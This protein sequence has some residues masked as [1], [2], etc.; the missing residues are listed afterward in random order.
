MTDL[1]IVPLML[2]SPSHSIPTSAPS[3]VVPQRESLINHDV[4]INTAFTAF[5][6]AHDTMVNLLHQDTSD[7]N[8][9]LDELSSAITSQIMSITSTTSLSSSVQTVREGLG[10]LPGKLQARHAH[11]RKQARALRRKIGG[12]DAREKLVRARS[13]ARDMR[14]RWG[15]KGQELWSSHISTRVHH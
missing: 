7:L 9:A 11:A 13:T 10:S 15:Q 6:Q 3:A 1:I 5:R 8:A 12:M 4:T 2:P 14:E